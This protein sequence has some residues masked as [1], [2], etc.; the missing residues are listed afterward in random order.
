M[1]KI[2]VTLAVVLVLMFVFAMGMCKNGA[3]VG[4]MQ[5]KPK[6]KTE[7]ENE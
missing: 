4:D 7:V 3:K 2:A 1:V 5:P 6:R